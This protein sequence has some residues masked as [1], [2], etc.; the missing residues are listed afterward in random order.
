MLLAIVILPN[1]SSPVT[2]V[3]SSLHVAP[4]IGAAMRE[5]GLAGNVLVNATLARRV[6]GR[7]VAEVSPTAAAQG[8][9]LSRA[10]R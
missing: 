1:A 3:H 5:A 10:G 6:G 4:T 8:V 7:P 9:Q 2:E